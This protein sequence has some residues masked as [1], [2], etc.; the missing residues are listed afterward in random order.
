MAAT[1][2]LLTLEQS[3]TYARID[4]IR[5]ESGAPRLLEMELTEPSLFFTQ[6]PG[7]ADR[8]A[9]VLARRMNA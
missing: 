7:S 4:L 6:A 2:Q 1:R 5:D 9:A 3:L 8:F